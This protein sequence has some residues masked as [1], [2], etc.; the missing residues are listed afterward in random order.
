MRRCCNVAGCSSRV[1]VASGR[2]RI[3]E[4]GVQV[5]ADY[6]NSRCC[7]I[8]AGWELCLYTLHWL[9]VLYY[10][11][12]YVVNFSPPSQ[13][14]RAYIM[15]MQ[16]LWSSRLSAWSLENLRPL[17]SHLLAFQAPCSEHWSGSSNSVLCV[18]MFI[19]ISPTLS[20]SLNIKKSSHGWG[21]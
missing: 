5:Q 10:V 3:I 9:H 16:R 21:W 1:L 8:M 20:T 19:D 6:C 4:R 7:Y 15:S 12:Y 2:S 11:L 14:K 13:K 17:R 18:A